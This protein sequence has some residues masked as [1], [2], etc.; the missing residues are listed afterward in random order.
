MILNGYIK[1]VILDNNISQSYIL[2]DFK[3]M[4]VLCRLYCNEK[5]GSVWV[6]ETKGENHMEK[7]KIS[8]DKLRTSLMLLSSMQKSRISMGIC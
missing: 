5:D 3:T 6:I 8:I 4:A 1:M 2:T 7:A